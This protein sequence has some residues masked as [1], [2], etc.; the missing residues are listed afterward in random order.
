MSRRDETIIASYDAFV[1]EDF[2]NR[3]FANRSY[4]RAR[5]GTGAYRSFLHFPLDIRKYLG[6]TI[7]EARLV[8]Y[9]YGTNP[10]ATY[11]FRRVTQRWREGNVTWNDQPSQSPNGEATVTAGGSDKDRMSV[12]VTAIV[13]SW[14]AGAAAYG[15]RMT[16]TATAGL[17]FYSS[18][19]AERLQPR[20]LVT[21]TP[22]AEIPAK[23]HPGAGNATSRLYPVFSWDADTPTQVHLQVDDNPDFLNPI[24]DSDW[25]PQTELQYDTALDLTF[26][27]LVDN[28]TYWWRIQYVDDSGTTSLWSDAAEFEVRSLGVLTITSPTSTVETTT[29]T[30][31]WTFTGR[32][33]ESFRLQLFAPD[34][35][36]P[37]EVKRTASNATSYEIPDGLLVQNINAYTVKVTVWDTYTRD[38]TDL[39]DEVSA[40]RSFTFFQSAAVASVTGLTAA[41][42]DGHVVV[43][44]SRVSTPDFFAVRANGVLI[45]DRLDPGEVSAGGNNYLFKVWD[46]QPGVAVTYSVEAVVLTSGVF[47]HSQSNPT[48]TVTFSPV[49]IWLTDPDTEVEVHILD[50]DDADGTIGETGETFFPLGRKGPVRLIDQVRGR[51]GSVSGTLISNAGRSAAFE[52]AGVSVMLEDVLATRRLIFGWLNIPVVIGELSVPPTPLTEEQYDITFSYWQVGEFD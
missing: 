27:P 21:W 40:S 25:V 1:A 10:S 35:T 17:V 24:W 15:F 12:D 4:L 46:A 28:T 30:V 5:S 32:L 51:E 50:T 18:E 36:Q 43:S 45:Y 41:V 13:Q 37:F 38:G 8:L 20:L 39:S 49:G 42:V 9:H 14:A 44:W 16:T 29:P 19:A 34:G 31:S 11:A 52:M 23:L 2:P 6:A 33:Q 22:G 7:I 3:N 47:K 48:A 26:S